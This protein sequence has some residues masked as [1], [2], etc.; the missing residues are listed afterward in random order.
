MKFRQIRYALAVL[1]SRS[2]TGASEV[3]HVSQSAISEQV[4]LL[5]A[6]LGFPLFRRTAHGVEPTKRGLLFFHEAERVS[7]EFH[8][9]VD[10]A[11]ALRGAEQDKIALGLM[12]GLAASLL[13]TIFPKDLP[14]F[15]GQLEIRT[16]PTGTIFDQ[17]RDGK[18]QFG[19][20]VRVDPERVPTGIVT[21]R[22]TE[23]SLVLVMPPDHRLAQSGGPVDLDELQDERLIMNELSVGYGRIVSDL[24]A[25]NRIR[26]KFCAIVDNIDTMKVAVQTGMGLAIMADESASNEE[27]LG[28]LKVRRLA[29]DTTIKIDVYYPRHQLSTH[30][31]EFLKMLLARIQAPSVGA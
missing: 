20:T 7:N 19:I 25:D 22:L 21:R 18:L 3:L 28:L 13:P 27:Q 26:P 11:R 15:D 5:E 17:L 31:G 24:L 6:L 10:V 29:I 12:S 30:Q 1:R 8:N 4:K 16:A 23:T 2:F 9:L 14:D